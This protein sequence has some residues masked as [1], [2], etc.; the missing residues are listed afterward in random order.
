MAITIDGK[1]YRNLQEQVAKNQADIQY[2]LEEEGVLNQF[3]V[4]VVNEVPTDADLPDP[5]TYEGE[6]GDAILVGTTQPFDMYIFTRPFGAET[7]NQWFNIGQFPL[8]GP[9]GIQGL[10]G[11][12]GEKGDKGDRGEVGPVGPQGAAGQSIVGPQG[13]QGIQGPIGPKGDPGES[14]KIVGTLT[15]VSLL[16]TP[17]EETRSSA[18]LVDIE[19]VNHLYVIVGEE[20]LTWFDA[21]PLEGIPG[22]TGETGP[23]G[24]AGATVDVQINGT[25]IVAD[26]VANIPYA[27]STQAGVMSTGTQNIA[28]LKRFYGTGGRTD[29][30]LAI[31]T[32]GS[33]SS[34]TLS[35]SPS[36]N[37]SGNLGAPFSTNRWN[38]IFANYMWCGSSLFTNSI[39]RINGWSQALGTTSNLPD[40][41]GTLL[42]APSAWTNAQSGSGIITEGGLYQFRVSYN[43][44]TTS[45]PIGVNISGLINF[46]GG[47]ARSQL[48]YIDNTRRAFFEITDT[49]DGTFT[50]ITNLKIVD[51]STGEATVDTGYTIQYR[52]IGI[53]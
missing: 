35:F 36:D 10:R 22:E 50:F 51:N 24:P 27:S 15:D 13:P 5:L 31:T 14:F 18:Y 43:A 45:D 52:R 53:A 41:E 42:S 48:I 34:T 23:Q 44:G 28:G 46:E 7:A 30:Y 8:P 16:P 1:I 4:K 17:T 47:T 21:G 39:Q 29:K 40:Y 37:G 32:S 26:G 49:A 38:N 11:E 20:D 9:Q 2:I 25:S 6:Y 33:G 19:G 3:G 12:K